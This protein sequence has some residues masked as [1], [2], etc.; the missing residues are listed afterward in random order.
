M[1][2]TGGAVVIAFAH[3]T[4]GLQVQIPDKAWKGFEIFFIFFVKFK[5][6]KK[7]LMLQTMLKWRSCK[8]FNAKSW[9][10][11]AVGVLQTHSKFFQKVAVCTVK[12]TKF[13]R[14]P[15]GIAVTGHCCTFYS[16][17]LQLVQNFCQFLSLVSIVVTWLL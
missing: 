12:F 16:W 2:S 17:Y 1:W 8:Q 10:E 15:S 9:N 11:S 13:T 7:N 5:K 6:F 14:I 4:Q 3:W